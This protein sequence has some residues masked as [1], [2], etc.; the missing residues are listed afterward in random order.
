MVTNAHGIPLRVA[1]RCSTADSITS[2]TTLPLCPPVVAAQLIASRSQQS[3]ENVARVGRGFPHGAVATD[4]TDPVA[5]MSH[6]VMRSAPCDAHSPAAL[7]WQSGQ[8]EPIVCASRDDE[9]GRRWRSG[10]AI[11][12]LD[13]RM[14]ERSHGLRHGCASRKA[15]QDRLMRPQPLS[16]RLFA[17]LCAH[18]NDRNDSPCYAIGYPR[19]ICVPKKPGRGDTANHSARCSSSMSPTP[20]TAPSCAAPST[21]STASPAAPSAPPSTGGCWLPPAWPGRPAARP[22]SP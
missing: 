13:A 15:R 1:K 3:Y 21:R 12:R 19:G 16:P 22:W 2:R 5:T 8:S 9:A 11:P 17:A 4:A 14:P 10:V 7:A 6:G 20:T 18:W